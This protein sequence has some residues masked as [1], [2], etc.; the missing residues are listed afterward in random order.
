MRLCVKPWQLRDRK[1]WRFSETNVVRVL[2][3]NE[4]GEFDA[5]RI[6]KNA[7]AA[8]K[9]QTPL[10]GGAVEECAAQFGILD[11][12]SWLGFGAAQREQFGFDTNS[13]QVTFELK[14]GSKYHLEFG[15]VSADG[16]HYGAAQYGE[17]TWF[18]ECPLAPYELLD[19]ALLKPG[20]LR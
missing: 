20:H 1:V 11:A 17:E 14:D 9:T 19:Y 6:E 15:G 13:L 18:F 3:K 10:N 8:P 12:L 4:L 2:V 16:Y 5:R 7:W